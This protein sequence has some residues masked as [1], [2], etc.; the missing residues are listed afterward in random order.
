MKKVLTLLLPLFLFSQSFED[1]KKQENISYTTYKKDFYTY[2]EAFLEAQ[3]EYLNK[4]KTFWPQK[5]L[6]TKN[7]WVQYSKNYQEKKVVDFEKQ[8]IHLNVIASSS[9][10]ARQKLLQ[11]LG[12]LLKEDVKSAYKNDQLE[13]NIS[14]K[15]KKKI[16]IHSKEKLIADVLNKSTVKKYKKYIQVRPLIKTLH[17]N[18][19]IYSLNL[20]LPSKAII[21]KALVHKD[22][23]SNDARKMSLPK[24]LVYAIIHS[25]SAFNP[26]ARSHIPAYGLMQIV[27]KSAGIDSYNFLY[28][29]KKLLSSSYLYDSKNNIKIGTAYLHILF[30]KYLKDIKN[31][32][33][34]LYCVIAA[35]NTG[36]GNVARAFYKTS[37]I[38]KAVQIINKMQAKDVYKQLMKKLPYKETIKYLY[39][40]NQKRF[41]YNKLIQDKVL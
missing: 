18:K 22:T 19:T 36:S 2:K 25:E 9:K 4:I 23:I 33:A 13:Q 34:R 17:N 20:K 29:K 28:G 40:V 11:S 1:F 38:K 35:Y 3:E 12:D 30:Y 24:E 6:S 10:E 26:M 41:V 8:A 39:K 16:T 27:P 31:E 5:E 37:N 21:N 14:K 7:K 15:L 32:E